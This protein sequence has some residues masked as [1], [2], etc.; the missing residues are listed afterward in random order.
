MKLVILGQQNVGKTTVIKRITK[1][2][3]SKNKFFENLKE[4]NLST[5]GIDTDTFFFDYED[6]LLAEANAEKSQ[7]AGYG[8][9]VGM[10]GAG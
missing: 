5:D 8:T 2:W 10:L 6:P 7:N 1:K 4:M 3:E 9:T